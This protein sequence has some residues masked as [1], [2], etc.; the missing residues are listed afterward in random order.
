MSLLLLASGCALTPQQQ[1]PGVDAENQTGNEQQAGLTALVASM[2]AGESS[3]YD[4][5][6]VKSGQS[7]H[8]ASG[9]VC[10][11]ITLT[12]PADSGN[13]HSELACRNSNGWFLVPNIFI[14]ETTDN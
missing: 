4:G 10:K 12:D 13:V 6:I 2:Q 7:Y 1:A 8:A 11:P 9:R 5:L 3:L 14:S